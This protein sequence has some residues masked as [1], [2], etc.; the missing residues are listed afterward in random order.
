MNE[1]KSIITRKIQKIATNFTSEIIYE[2]NNNETINIE[3]C[4]SMRDI[5]VDFIKSNYKDDIHAEQICII[6]EF[7][8]SH[9]I[10]VLNL[11][12]ALGMKLGFE[13][14]RLYDLGIAAILHDLGFSKLPSSIT[15]KP[16]TQLNKKEYDQY[17]LHPVF[18]AKM[19]LE[20]CNVPPHIAEIILHHHERLD[21]SGYPQGLRD[22]KINSNSLIIGLTCYYDRL[23]YK[24]HDCLERSSQ[25]IIKEILSNGKE[26]FPPVYLHSFAHLF[27]FNSATAYYSQTD[28]FK[29]TG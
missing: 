28:W 13:K 12:I 3:K 19:A 23:N 10:N 9:P 26:K 5:L 20:D 8:K 29:S 16:V 22:D 27:Y 21:G 14:E 7:Q 6:D 11:S 2:L 1:K 4:Y 24:K 18:G 17:K 25:H 15:K